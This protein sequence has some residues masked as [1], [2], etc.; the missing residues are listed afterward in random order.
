MRKLNV[1]SDRK[2]KTKHFFFKLLTLFLPFSRPYNPVHIFDFGIRNSVFMLSLWNISIIQFILEKQ[3]DLSDVIR[4]CCKPYYLV[5]A[6]AL[7]WSSG[8]GYSWLQFLSLQTMLW[9]KLFFTTLLSQNNLGWN[10]PLIQPSS[11]QGKTLKK[12]ENLKVRMRYSEPSLITFKIP[13]NTHLWGMPLVTQYYMGSKPLFITLWAQ[14]LSGFSTHHAL[15][16]QVTWF[17][18][19]SVFFLLMLF[20]LV[21]REA[22]S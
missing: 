6:V 5:Y 9:V 4:S 19:L 22:H 15:P 2:C 10:W 8:C 17:N 7:H 18:Q 21:H 13:P 16:W 20:Y 1:G 14:Q 12:N 3:K 11:L